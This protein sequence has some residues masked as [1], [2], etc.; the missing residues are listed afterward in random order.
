MSAST[1]QMPHFFEVVQSYLKNGDRDYLAQV[2]Q[3]WSP[4]I[5][6][7]HHIGEALHEAIFRNDETAV[8]MILDAGGDPK[9][10][11]TGDPGF[12]PLLVASQYGRLEIASLFWRLVGPDA[13]FYPSKRPNLSCLQVAARNGHVE[14]VAYFLDVWNGWTDDEKRRALSDAS[15]SWCDD[16]VALLLAKVDYAPDVVQGALEAVVR[17]KL[18]LPEDPR[19]PSPK[20]EDYVYQQRIVHRLIDAGANPDI[21]N[22]RL[23]NQPL[24]H[25][26]SLSVG[27]IGAMRGLLEKGGNANAQDSHGRSALQCL[28]SRPPISTDAVRVLLQ[29]G[30]SLEMTG[31]AGETLLHRVAQNGTIEQLNLCVSYSDDPDT[32]IRSVTQHGESLLHYAAAGGREDVVDFLLTSGLDV[33]SATSNGWTPLLCALSRT[34]TKREQSLYRLANTLLQRGANAQ[35]VTAE[36]WTP[37]HALATWPTPFSA[38]DQEARKAAA[39]PLVQELISRGAPVDTE[40]IVIQRPSLGPNQLL[41]AWGFRMQK[42]VEDLAISTQDQDGMSTDTT[43]LM[44]AM[45]SNAMDIFELIRAHLDSTSGGGN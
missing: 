3:H 38:Q 9:V 22:G 36:G 33:N 37:L 23:S 31:E 2:L 14:L 39:P 26:A 24:I 6:P 34:N 21:T 5:D 16:V 29:H 35:V 45:R 10:Q 42:F 11:Q 40:S 20:D 1:P 15:S 44:W 28:V 18:I 41:D 8:R 13:R 27:C 43:P 25:T 30:A 17:R 19:K 32:A 12:T 4:A 7:S